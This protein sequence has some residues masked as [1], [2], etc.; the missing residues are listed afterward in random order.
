MWTPDDRGV[1]E[2][3]PQRVRFT[4]RRGTVDCPEVQAVDLVRQ[5]IPWLSVL[6]GNALILGWIFS[7]GT[8]F[9]TLDNPA[10]VPFLVLLNVFLLW[11]MGSMRWARVE[12]RDAS[13]DRRVAC[14]SDGRAF[15]WGSIAGGTTQL[16]EVM[17]AA[18][19][20]NSGW[21]AGG[22]GVPGGK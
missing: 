10:T 7:G 16:F 19:L 22:P 17:K 13:G 11:A 18:V 15:G 6:I 14:F 9:F 21:P 8:S 2:L 5:R 4:G 20:A 3:F 1:L 12:Y